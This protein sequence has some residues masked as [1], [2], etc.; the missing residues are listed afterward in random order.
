MKRFIFIGGGVAA[1]TAVKELRDAGFDGEIVI[2]TDEPDLPY[3]RPPLSK[4]WL[5]GQFDRGQFR[6]NPQQWY[7]DN[8][9]DVLLSTRAVRI[10]T[11]KR[12]V[13]LSDAR[14]LTYDALILATGVR[15]KTLPGFAGDRVHVMRSLSD[16]ERLRE[17]LVPGHHLAVLG[18]GFLGCEVAAFAVA[19]GLRV[20][21]FDPGALPLGRAVCQEIGRAMI[22]IHREHGVQM[23]TGEIV[24]AIN[25]TPTH[26]ELTTGRGE[27]VICDDVLV[28]IGSVPNIELAEQAGIEVDG[29]ILTDEYGRTSAPDVYAIGDVAARFHPVYGRMFRVEHHDT[30]M[31]HGVNVARN[32]LGQPVPFTEEHFFWSQQYEHSLQAYGQAVGDCVEVIRGSA[33]EKSLSV[34]SLDGK[35]IKAITCLNR[36]QD[37]MQ[38]RKIMAIPHEVTKEQLADPAFELKSLLPKPARPQRREVNA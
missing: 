10:D 11:E 25:E 12:E 13:E 37:L 19:K 21:V 14:S 23:R 34:F 28:A 30:A 5:T 4:D 1:V 16:A 20:T 8:Q 31:R 7:A 35:R 29:G 9:V 2:V 27:V 6:I 3:E 33:K 36:P 26:V 15:A 18:A 24:A 17:R 32:L 38:A 22:D